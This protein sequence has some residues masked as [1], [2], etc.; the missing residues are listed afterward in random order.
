MQ[1]I[2]VAIA[3]FSLFKHLDQKRVRIDTTV[4]QSWVASISLILVTTFRI[5]ICL[6]L[7]AAFTQRMW[8]IVRLNPIK[9]A[10][11]DKYFSMQR[12]A[13]MLFCSRVLRQAPSLYAMVLIGFTI[14]LAV[15]FPP[16]ALTVEGRLYQN[17]QP[18]TVGV[19][20]ASF[21]GNGS[22]SDALRWSLAWPNSMIAISS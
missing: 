5:S 14:G 18:Q 16:G 2:C 19:F 22:M 7:G 15:V 17:V 4:P 10:D 6:S 13:L 1:A 11:L 20:N 8:H 12:D 9:V 3:H 21:M